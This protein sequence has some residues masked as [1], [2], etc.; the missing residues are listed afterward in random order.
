MITV[1]DPSIALVSVNPEACEN[2][3]A[4]RNHRAVAVQRFQLTMGSVQIEKVKFS[5]GVS[6]QNPGRDDKDKIFCA[7]ERTAVTT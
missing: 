4:H 3:S 7:R 5:P 2:C 1:T 6:C